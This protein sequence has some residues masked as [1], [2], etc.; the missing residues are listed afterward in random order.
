MVKKEKRQK[1]DAFVKATNWKN[2]KKTLLN[3]D[4]LYKQH[5]D[6]NGWYIKSA[7]TDIYISIARKNK[8][9]FE[10]ALKDPQKLQ[11]FLT[12]NLN[13]WL[14]Q[15]ALISY[16]DYEEWKKCQVDK[17]DF[18][19]REV[20]VGIDLSKCL[21]LY[22]VIYIEKFGELGGGLIVLIILIITSF[23]RK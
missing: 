7:V 16:L 8:L 6:N 13:I 18:D 11:L 17:I 22:I 9:Y 15:D 19:G 5:K 4:D 3:I 12:K 23:N 1:F 10:N 14:A 21:L 20:V 2:V